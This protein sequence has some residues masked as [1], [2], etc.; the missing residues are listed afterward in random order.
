MRRRAMRA[1]ASAALLLLALATPAGAQVAT[2]RGYAAIAVTAIKPRVEAL[3]LIERETA[4]RVKG[5]D[6]RPYE[7]LLEQAR[8]VA[9]AIADPAGL[10]F[11]ASLNRCRNF[12]PA[13]R[14]TCA[15]ASRALVTVI[16]AQIAGGA[17]K[18]AR[19]A[20][21][22]AITGCERLVRL[23]PLSTALRTID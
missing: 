7:W 4:D 21:V 1:S 10:Q 20:Y 11:K 8:L 6:T 14:R 18:A 3:R 12:I 2:C 17:P 5:L 13:T 9:S 22:D 23:M 19:Q 15:A 16:E